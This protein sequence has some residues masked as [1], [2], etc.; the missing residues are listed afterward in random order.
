MPTYIPRR[1][2]VLVASIEVLV[3]LGLYAIATAT[4]LM[5]FHVF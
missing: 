1:Y 5:A 2:C 3:C 4:G